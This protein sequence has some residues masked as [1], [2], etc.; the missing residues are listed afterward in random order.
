MDSLH[1]TRGE[2]EVGQ[3]G[4]LRNSIHVHVPLSVGQRGGN[5][6]ALQMC[7]TFK[8]RM[9]L[10]CWSV[11]VKCL[12]YI[13][14]WGLKT[15]FSHKRLWVQIMLIVTNV[16]ESQTCLSDTCLNCLSDKCLN[17]LSDKCLRINKKK[18]NCLRIKHAFEV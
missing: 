12:C 4:L 6:F 9:F 11:W 14:V 1:S 17:C 13:H 18:K 3:R 5:G 15:S 7:L 16:F 2:Q 8:N 10:G